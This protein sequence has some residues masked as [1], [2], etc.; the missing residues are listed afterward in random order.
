LA[1]G[2]Q[3]PTGFT[4]VGGTFTIDNGGTIDAGT[5]VITA[6]VANY[7]VTYTIAATGGCG[8][9]S[10]TAAVNIIAT[11]TAAISYTGS[12]FCS[13]AAPASP[14]FTGSATGG[15][16]TSTAGLTI[17]GTT[18]IVTVVGS[19][20]ATYTIAYDVAA[21]TCPVVHETTII[22]INTNVAP[23]LTATTPV[24]ACADAPTVTLET[25]LG[26]TTAP[27][28]TYVWTV[29]A[30]AV[31]GAPNDNQYDIAPVAT[32]EAGSYVVVATN[33]C[34]SS[35]A[36]VVLTVNAL[37]VIT[38]VAYVCAGVTATVQPAVAGTYTY[39]LTAQTGGTLPAALPFIQNNNAT[40]TLG[41]G[42][43][44]AE[45]TIASGSCV[46]LPY[47]ADF[48][49]CPGGALP[50]K[51][52]YFKGEIVAKDNQLV[53]GTATEQNSAWFMIEASNDGLSFK[54]IGRKRAAGNSTTPLT[55]NFTHT[56]VPTSMYYRLRMMDADG[57]FEFSNTV[58]LR[59]NKGSLAVNNVFPN[60][61][62]GMIT[63]QYEVEKPSQLKFTIT[64]ELGRR[65]ST[66]TVEAVSG[67]NNQPLDLADFPG[68]AYFLL[69]DEADGKRTVRR[70]VKQ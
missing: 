14:T 1:S 49:G 31:N 54:E 51:L 10:S 12:P 4:P 11:P 35:T 5:G 20:P 30:T 37:P 16:Y 47:S 40:F 33:V 69:I 57:S 2:N 7:T 21:G 50:V 63:V 25:T 61:T 28:P 59:R 55:Y 41:A 9:T 13:S 38:N 29:P 70:V 43:V 68:G 22:E 58:Y 52:T 18:G 62:E 66:K 36:T 6:A 32:T 23:T 17:D 27:A 53:W 3:T 64:D 60:P 15:T 48:S 67:V 8:P 24:A 39:T 34:G 45:F 19:T 44:D 65:L 26:A 42:T 46:S 56:D